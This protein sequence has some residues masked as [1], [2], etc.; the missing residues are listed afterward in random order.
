MGVLFAV[1]YLSINGF[2][3]FSQKIICKDHLSP[4]EQNYYVGLYNAL[5]YFLLL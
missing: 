4:D 2:V 3:N 1:I 5:I